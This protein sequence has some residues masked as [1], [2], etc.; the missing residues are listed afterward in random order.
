MSVGLLTCLVTFVFSRTV[1]WHFVF[2]FGIPVPSVINEMM[3]DLLFFFFFLIV[4]P[5][6]IKDRILSKLNCQ[7]QTLLFIFTFMKGAQIACPCMCM[8]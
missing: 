1:G 7:V 8:A 2:D 4:L 5:L 6:F 3:S